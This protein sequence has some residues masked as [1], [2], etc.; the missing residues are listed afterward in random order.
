M[1]RPEEEARELSGQRLQQVGWVIQDMAQL[2]GAAS[3]VSPYASAPR[4]LAPP[5][6]CCWWTASRSVSSKP[7]MARRSGAS[8]KKRHKPSATQ[9]QSKG[10]ASPGGR[11]ESISRPQAK[12]I[13]FTGWL[14]L[15]LHS[16]ERFHF[17]QPYA[18]PRTSRP[19]LSNAIRAL[20]EAVLRDC[21][22]S[23]LLSLE[24]MLAE[25]RARSAVHKEAGAIG[26]DVAGLPRLKPSQDQ[27][28]A[29]LRPAAEVSL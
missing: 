8:H 1:T 29:G 15:L 3:P 7:S 27:R 12:A 13:R 28:S 21:Q 25:N 17:F 26:L 18:A 10:G 6:T 23:A 22:V 20:H 24:E 4:I 19:R 11:F 16:R 14:D 2:N 9:M 5:T